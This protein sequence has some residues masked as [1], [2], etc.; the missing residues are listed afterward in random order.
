MTAVERGTSDAGGVGAVVLA[1]GSSA[2]MRGRFKLLEEAGGRALVWHA[3]SA[4][5]ASVADPVVVV[6]GHRA[7]EVEA[8][9]PDGALVVHNPDH[10]DGMSS[11]LAAGLRALPEACR[12]ALVMLGDMPLV[13]AGLC[14]L[15]VARLGPK[16]IA[17]PVVN[18]VRGHP[19]AWSRTY[20]EE[21]LTVVGDRG[22]REVM[23]RHADAVTLVARSDD[24]PLSDVD[25]PDDLA[26]AH[27]RLEAE[28]GEP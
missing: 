6:T 10:A 28:P 12:G 20:F 14:D 21:I 2:R 19:V 3:V 18:G 9:L 26:R 23:D 15:L 7:A 25:D 24:A 13:D 16:G 8:V 17:V 27:R 5:L 4:A 11:S 1:A 22:A